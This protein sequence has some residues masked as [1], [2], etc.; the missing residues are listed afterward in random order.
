MIELKDAEQLSK[1]TERAK[2]GN[3]FVQPSGQ[4]RMYYVTNRDNGNRYTVN[5]FV[6]NGKRYGHCDCKAG[7]NHVACKH[8]SAAAALHVVRAA[9]SATQS[10]AATIENAPMI[11]PA[12]SKPQEKWR[13]IAI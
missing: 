7:M 6:R 3:L 8:L 1:A 10:S 2:A 13:G 11:Q 12:Q 4:F 5:F 9:E